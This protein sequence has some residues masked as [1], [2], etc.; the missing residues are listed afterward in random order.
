M[1][2]GNQKLRAVWLC[3]LGL[4]LLVSACTQPVQQTQVVTPPVI[5]ITQVITEVIPATTAVATATPEPTATPVPP[6][7]T[8]TW[9]PLSAPIYYPLADCVASRLHIGDRVMVSL[10]GGPNG[11]RYGRNIHDDTIIAYAQ[12]GSILEI[13][14]GPWCSHGWIVWMVRMQDGLTGYTPEGNGEE[15]WLLPLQP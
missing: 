5:V 2:N 4:L 11:I 1:L 7:P 10:V 6:T 8:P 3:L 15:Y 12:P 14:N 13:V 9:D